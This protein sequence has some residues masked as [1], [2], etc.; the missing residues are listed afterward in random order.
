M[1][2]PQL[3]SLSSVGLQR[4]QPTQL[5]LLGQGLEAAGVRLFL[6]TVEV[7]VQVVGQPAAD[8][9]T[10]AVRVPEAITPGIYGLR[11]GV[12]GGHLQCAGGER[13]QPAHR[14]VG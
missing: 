6:G 14:A 11:S 9:L 8:R 7:P 10:L 2:V 1:A 13:G 3:Q 12:R 4:A 5:V